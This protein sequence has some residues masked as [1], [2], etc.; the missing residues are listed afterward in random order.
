MKVYLRKVNLDN[1]SKIKFKIAVAAVLQTKEQV[2][3]KVN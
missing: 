3:N 2:F 1:I